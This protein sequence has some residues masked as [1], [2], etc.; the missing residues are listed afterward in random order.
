MDVDT[1]SGFKLP[2]YATKYFENGGV[3]GCEVNSWETTSQKNAVLAP[4]VGQR[5]QGNKLALAA[6]A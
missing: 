5:Q 1:T 4:V 3:N 6:V 2:T